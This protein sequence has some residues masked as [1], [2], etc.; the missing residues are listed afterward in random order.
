MLSI[1]CMSREL[2]EKNNKETQKYKT[3]NIFK[4]IKKPFKIALNFLIFFQQVS[5]YQSS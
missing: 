2:K 4:V 5:S 3:V 1:Y